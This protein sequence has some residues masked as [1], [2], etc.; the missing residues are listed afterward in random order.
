MFGRLDEPL[1]YWPKNS[2]ESCRVGLGHG[3]H[4]ATNWPKSLT[5]RSQ[6]ARTRATQTSLLKGLY[7]CCDYRRLYTG[8]ERR[9]LAIDI[10]ANY[11]SC[12]GRVQRKAFNEGPH[13]QMRRAVL[14]DN[15]GVLVDTELLFF[16]ATREI[17][18]K[19]GIDLSLDVYVEY[20]LQK[21]QSCLDLAGAR[22]WNESQISD[23]RHYRYKLLERMVANMR[24]FIQPTP[25]DSPGSLA[26][27]ACEILHHSLILSAQIGGIVNNEPVVLVAPHDVAL[28]IAALKRAGMEAV[29]K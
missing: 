29:A 5:V 1:E 14:F 7:L 28:A 10:S 6:N 16:R 3:R 25:T 11:L 26:I 23:L 18:R 22:G 19:A 20:A 17:L 24:I 13:S 15:D 2:H 27:R 4:R 9:A 21:G 8:I 12:R